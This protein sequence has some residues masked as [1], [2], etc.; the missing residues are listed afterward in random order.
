[1]LNHISHSGP[2][3]TDGRLQT[4]SDRDETE[5]EEFKQLVAGDHE[6]TKPRKQ[7]PTRRGGVKHRSFVEKQRLRALAARQKQ[8]APGPGKTMDDSGI[9]AVAQVGAKTRDCCAE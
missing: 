2:S 1:M 5:I 8:D 6:A 9:V 3:L 4:P 7:R